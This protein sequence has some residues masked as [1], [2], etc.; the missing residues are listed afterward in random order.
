MN[1]AEAP[2]TAPRGLQDPVTSRYQPNA[3][4]TDGDGRNLD[5]VRLLMRI[6]GLTVSEV[7]KAGG[8]SR[9]TA[10][11]Y[12][13]RLAD[14]GLVTRITEYGKAGRPQVRYLWR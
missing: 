5:R 1:I 3:C 13:E 7:A 9:V 6:F 10:W 12:L 8:V 4:P 11:R 14:E 2:E